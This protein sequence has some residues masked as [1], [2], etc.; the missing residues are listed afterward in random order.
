MKNNSYSSDQLSPDEERRTRR[1]LTLLAILI[2][3]G[4]FIG[5]WH[6]FSYA[7]DQDRILL[8][9]EDAYEREIDRRWQEIY[10]YRFQTAREA[11][12]NREQQLH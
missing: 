6:I 10:R 5:S 11:M 12:K 9:K 2:C 7:F 1:Q 3:F 8:Q 4:V